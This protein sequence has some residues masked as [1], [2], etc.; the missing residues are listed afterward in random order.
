[1][2]QQP[3][4]VFSKHKNRRAVSTS[5]P[6]RNRVRLVEEN[7]DIPNEIFEDANDPA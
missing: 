2:R 4:T 6:S 5:L 3:I 1:M 7:D